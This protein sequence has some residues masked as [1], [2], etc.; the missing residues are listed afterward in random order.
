M[1]LLFWSFLAKPK[2][3]S[4]NPKLTSFYCLTVLTAS[5]TL[6]W[7]V[8]VYVSLQG[9]NRKWVVVRTD[10]ITHSSTSSSCEASTVRQ[11]DRGTGRSAGPSYQASAYLPP[12]VKRWPDVNARKQ[13]EPFVVHLLVL[14]N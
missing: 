6:L 3:A 2:D 10:K 1:Q 5:C 12:L 11:R 7:V 14:C 9:A 13:Q 4:L 8:V